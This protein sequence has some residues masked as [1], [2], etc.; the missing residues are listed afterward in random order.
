MDPVL[1][2][3]DGTRAAVPALRLAAA[4]AARDGVAVELV[5]V[6]RPIADMVVALPHREELEQAH[7]RGVAERVRAQLIDAV[8]SLDWPLH[9][10]VGRPA[11]AIC[12]VARH[13]SASLIL[14]GAARSDPEGGGTALE[15]IQLADRPVLST[16]SGTMP[17]TAV[18][19]IDFRPGSL[20]A[21]M[22]AFRLV[23]PDGVLHLVHVRPRLDFPAALV[24]DWGES[25]E[26]EVSHGFERL[27]AALAAAGAG[28]TR[29]HTVEGDPAGA[30]AAVSAETHADLLAVG[31]DGY[32]FRGRVVIG[33]VAQRLV[34]EAPV[35]VVAIPDPR[36]ENAAIGEAEAVG[37]PV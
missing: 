20:N 37:H 32:T 17:R 15:V 10:R 1:V 14:L 8:G 27:V 9:V 16:R 31:S 24:W 22:E 25:Y 23:G 35:A 30:L 18:V 19:G 12:E 11:A 33:R 36:G 34:R 4:F 21:A 3:T 26:C 6:V 13:R 7:A 29:T 5:S 2:A 28:D